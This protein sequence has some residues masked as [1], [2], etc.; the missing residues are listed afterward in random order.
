M[1]FKLT[2]LIILL[3]VFSFSLPCFAKEKTITVVYNN[4][5]YNNDLTCAWGMSCFIDGIG[6]GILFDTGGDGEILLFNMEKLEIDPESIDVVVLSHIHADHMGGLWDLLEKNNKISVYLP[7]SFSTSF[8]D[9]ASKITRVVISVDKPIK[10]CEGVWS[11]GQLGT[12]IKEQSLI[13]NTEKGL[14][15]V[16][17]CAHPGIVNIV[18]KA[19][20]MFENKVYLVLGGFHLISYNENQ[21][22]EIIRQLKDLGVQ[23]VGPSHCTGG[24]P[25]ELF[26]QAWGEDFVNLGCGAKIKIP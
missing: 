24:G 23:K 21:V 18:E 8:K 6:K 4:V 10:I 11:T 12:W 3:S 26:R 1:N 2:K 9:R 25:I 15:V 13:I 22:R 7:G 5:S 14:V 20:D 19:K 16:T 17:G